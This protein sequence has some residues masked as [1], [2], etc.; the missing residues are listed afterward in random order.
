M[1]GINPDNINRLYRSFF[2]YSIGFNNLLKDICLKNAVLQN[3]VWR[4][5]ALLL[6]YCSEGNFDTMIGE[7]ER[8]KQI[9]LMEMKKEI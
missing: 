4:V 2:V 6:E 9:K 5:F 1:I 8:D 3:S 7:I